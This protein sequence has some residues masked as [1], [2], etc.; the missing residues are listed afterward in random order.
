MGQ[1][2]KKLP[3]RLKRGAEFSASFNNP[4]ESFS[5]IKQL[6]GMQ[7]QPQMNNDIPDVGADV[8]N[9]NRAMQKMREE[10]PPVKQKEKFT[11]KELDQYYNELQP[12]P[13]D[14]RLEALKKL[15][16]F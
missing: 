15:R 9:Y 12:P 10:V 3:A 4:K 6:M 14:P 5:G 11:D 1:G 13:V 8:D 2:D 7:P 16:G